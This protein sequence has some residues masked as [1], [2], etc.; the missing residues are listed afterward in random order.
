MQGGMP[1]PRSLVKSTARCFTLDVEGKID[2]LHAR[3][4]G[5]AFAPHWHEEFAV[6]LINEGVEQ[7]EYRGA[8]RQAVTGQVVLMNAGELHTG[9]AADERGFGFCMLYIPE[10]TFRSIAG[11]SQTVTAGLSFKRA[12]LDDERLAKLLFRTHDSLSEGGSSLQTEGLLIDALSHILAR[13]ATWLPERI[14]ARSTPL[15]DRA[16]DYLQDNIFKDVTLSE[17]AEVAGLSKYHFLRQ[18]RKEYGMPPH[19]FQLQQRIFRSKVLLRSQTT[20]DVAARCGFADQSHFH[21]VFRSHVGATPGCY[22]EQFRS[23][24]AR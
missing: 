13:T 21:R 18:F 24:H 10:S 5:H 6:G 2:V 16:R 23:R 4:P 15:L 7:F 12:I 3:Y 17:L 11:H 20:V 8:V 22:A 1:G 9:E 19:A 14:D